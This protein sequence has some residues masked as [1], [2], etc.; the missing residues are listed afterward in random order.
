MVMAARSF[1]LCAER[2]VS[3]FSTLEIASVPGQQQSKPPTIFCG[4]GMGERVNCIVWREG[5]AGSPVY[6]EQ[7]GDMC[8]EGTL[9]KGKTYVRTCS[10][11]RCDLANEEV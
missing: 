10:N 3:R 4:T 1:A 2:D 5:R 9:G 8:L 11:L 6:K 7:K